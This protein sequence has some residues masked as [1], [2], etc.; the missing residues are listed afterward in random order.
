VSSSKRWS[1]VSNFPP[2]DP[3][4]IAPDDLVPFGDMSQA[5][6][7]RQRTATVEAIRRGVSGVAEI[8]TATEDTTLTADAIGAYVRA[9]AAAVI[10]LPADAQKGA[11]I[12][13]RHA[14]AEADAV[15]VAA[16]S[17][18]TVNSP[19]GL[20]VSYGG[21]ATFVCVA[22]GVWDGAGALEGA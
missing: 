4:L 15:S 17:G 12:V 8:I 10:T 21:A 19:A 1:N 6:G 7:E 9:T 13:V 14:A 20:V 16:P 2:M 3:A 18:G 22:D 5:S 11:Y